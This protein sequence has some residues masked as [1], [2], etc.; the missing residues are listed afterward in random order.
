VAFD[1]ALKGDP[2]PER[3]RLAQLIVAASATSAPLIASFV[4]I[5]STPAYT[6]NPSTQVCI[7]RVGAHY[8][9]FGQL[10]DNT[11]IWFW[12]GSHADDDRM[13]G[14]QKR[15]RLWPGDGGVAL[16]ANL[17]PSC[18]IHCCTASKNM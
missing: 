1:Y 13:I 5:R 4:N 3:G 6:S 17:F 14:Q 16:P 2:T 18:N 12:I 9:A 8:R 7:L 15:L 11:I 10:H